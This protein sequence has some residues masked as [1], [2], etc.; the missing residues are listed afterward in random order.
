LGY[1]EDQAGI[2]VEYY[3]QT[4]NDDSRQE[5]WKEEQKRYGFDERE[6][7]NLEFTFVAWIYPRLKM[8]RER[9]F[10]CPG[11]VTLD[12]W[13]EILDEMIDGFESYLKDKKGIA[14]EEMIKKTEKSLELFKEWFWDLWW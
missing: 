4:M 9:N 7:W 8:F 5:Q 3:W 11:S 1:Y 10:G 2:E 12:E 13:H 6:T 14:S